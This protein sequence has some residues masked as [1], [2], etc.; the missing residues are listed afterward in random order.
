MTSFAL[1]L[2]YCIF[3]NVI[4]SISTAHAQQ[5]P[6]AR[7]IPENSSKTTI[8]QWFV[9][10]LCTWRLPNRKRSTIR[11][12]ILFFV[13]SCLPRVAATPRS[14]ATDLGSKRC[15]SVFRSSQFSRL[16][17]RTMVHVITCQRRPV[18][19]RV[20]ILIRY[21]SHLRLPRAKIWQSYIR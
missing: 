18:D 10:S 19:R 21:I 11:K 4:I 8:F 6:S 9:S 14:R 5:L 13:E 1:Y 15:W 2:K 16:Q 3:L 17:W 20:L 12:A 7:L